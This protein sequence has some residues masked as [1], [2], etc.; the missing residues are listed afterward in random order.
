VFGLSKFRRRRAPKERPRKE[1]RRRP[2]PVRCTFK[3]YD[4]PLKPPTQRYPTHALIANAHEFR[5]QRL[6]NPSPAEDAFASILQS[7][8]VSFERERIF[9]RTGSFIIADF[10]VR[11]RDLV[12]EVDGFQHSC[13]IG[14]DAGRDQ[15][16]KQA[17]G[18][19]TVRISASTVLRSRATCEVLVRAELGL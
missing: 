14:Y 13:Q 15:W 11:S 17:H 6:A 2:I 9:Y 12:F 3:L 19:R 16:L 5:A 7:L 4:N 8:G 18:I 1:K 10:F